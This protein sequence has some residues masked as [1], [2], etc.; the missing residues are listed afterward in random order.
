[1]PQQ[2]ESTPSRRGDLLDAAHALGWGYQRT[3]DAVCR[4]LLHGGRD[5]STRLWWVDLDDIERVAKEQAA[6]SAA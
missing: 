1:M 6:M 4:G 5:P 2:G 3:R